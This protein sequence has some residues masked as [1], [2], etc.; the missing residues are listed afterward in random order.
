MKFTN[1]H[2]ENDNQNIMATILKN[3]PKESGLTKIEY[4]G[5]SISLHTINPRFLMETSQLLTN[6]VNVI[7]KRIVI[8]TDESIRKS[9]KETSSII[10]KY[11]G[12]KTIDSIFF[13]DALGEITIYIN[14]PNNL[15]NSDLQLLDLIV[16]TGWKIKIRKSSKAGSS[17]QF[18]NNT[19]IDATDYRIGFYKKVGESIF[20]SKLNNIYE[21]SLIALGGCGEIGRSCFLIVTN[22]SKILLDCGINLQENRALHH[23]P[24]MDI[25]GFKPEEIDGVVLSHAHMDHTGFLPYLYKY[26]YRGP[27]YCTEPTL[28]LMIMLFLDYHKNH[29]LYSDQ[30]IKN[31][32][33]HTIPLNLGDVTDIAPD[34]KLVFYNS[35]HV[36]GSS[37][38]HLHIG[39]GDHNIVYTGD[40]KFGK[41]NLLDNATWNFPRVETLIIEGTFGIKESPHKREESDPILVESINRTIRSGGKVL[42]PVPIIGLAQELIYSLNLYQTTG[43]LDLADIYID[44]TILEACN[45]YEM[46]Q[47]YLSHGL[48]TSATSNLFKY[49]NIKPI[50]AKS[51]IN[52]PSIIL[53]PSS[54]LIGGTSV[55]ILKQLC[56]DSTNKILFLSYQSHGTIG[57]EIQLGSKEIIIN[58]QTV[59][60]NCQIDSVY[61]FSNHSDYNQLLA[62]VSRLKPKLRRVLVNHGEKARVQNLAVSINKIL[63]IQSQYLLV[64]EATK[65]L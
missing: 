55:R 34:I 41:T 7:R 25:T 35:G 46:Y 6:M 57:K 56:N 37:S 50:P 54:M 8:R 61:G 26:G 3:L 27:V 29:G 23:F 13:D 21:A 32:I 64:P 53:A 63:N 42:I 39:N 18:I 24:R 38:I 58:G 49:D 33:V 51:K 10:N 44:N 36:L 2:Y 48:K 1:S 17:I 65:L 19:L 16:K 52:K 47:D 9:H 59:E 11:Y 22:E 31:V 14:Y 20:R 4:E 45:I 28:P 43:K 62:Y 12:P 40:L 30:D 5:P 15:I 60:I